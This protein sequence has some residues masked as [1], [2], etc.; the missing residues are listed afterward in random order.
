MIISEE[1]FAASLQLDTGEYLKFD[2]TGEMIKYISSNPET[3]VLAWWVHD[4]DSSEWVR[5][6]EAYYVKST[7]LM[8]PM[9]TGIAVFKTKEKA[10]QFAFEHDGIVYN[11]EEIRSQVQMTNASH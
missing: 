10:D 11:L 8:T 9:G 4:Y 3:E 7:T 5:G 1:R 6:E 2:D